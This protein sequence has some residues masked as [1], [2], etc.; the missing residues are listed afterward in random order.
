MRG[1]AKQ[2]WIK[3]QYSRAPLLTAKVFYEKLLPPALPT[4]VKPSAG[5]AAAHVALAVV[6]F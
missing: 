3:K 1:S 4:K 2:Y 5:L 6:L